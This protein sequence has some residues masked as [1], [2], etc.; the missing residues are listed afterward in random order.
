MV[1]TPDG[2]RTI[3]TERAPGASA[4][5]T[6]SAAEPEQ[7]FTESLGLGRAAVLSPAGQ[8]AGQ[9][10]APGGPLA[11]WQWPGRAS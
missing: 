1:I 5:G 10:S 4:H 9:S 8:L 3:D 11:P 7:T 2:S 6:D